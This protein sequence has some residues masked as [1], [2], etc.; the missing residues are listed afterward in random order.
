MI[1]S[2]GA[3]TSDVRIQTA[4]GLMPAYVSTPVT[5]GPWPGV[6]VIHDAFGMT[7][8]LRRQADW[9]AGEGFLAVAPDLY[10]WG[11]RLA[12]M[13][14]VLRDARARTGPSFDDIEAARAF[15]TAHEDCTGRIGVIGYCMG[16]GFA[17]LLAPSGGYDASGVNY[18]VVAKDVV[19]ESFLSGACPIVASYGAKDLPNRGTAARLGRALTAAGVEHDVKEYPGAGHSFL[20][21][22]NPK[23]VPLLLVPTTWILR[24]GYHEP[25]ARDARRRIVDFFTRQLAQ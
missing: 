17:L 21:Q 12:C 25:S 7:D 20:N 5:P 23:D 1:T 14:A 6:V 2:G 11:R 10:H 15:L 3:V 9:L 22:H 8:D 24:S 18:S 4:R 19:S 16:G 13:R